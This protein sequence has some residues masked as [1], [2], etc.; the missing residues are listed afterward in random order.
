MKPLFLGPPPQGGTV[1]MKLDW[2][3][4]ALMQIEMATQ[5][6]PL[7]IADTFTVTTPTAKHAL[8][9]STATTLDVAKVLGTLLLDMRRRG[10][11]SGI[12]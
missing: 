6:D 3:M 12:G 5:A 10:V 11:N 9:V 1:D 8:D 7:A 2:C 4:R